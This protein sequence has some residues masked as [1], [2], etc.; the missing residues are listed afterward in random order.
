MQTVKQGCLDH[1][2]VVAE[3]HLA[4]L[5]KEFVEDRH[6]KGPHRDSATC[7]W[8]GRGRRG[9]CGPSGMVKHSR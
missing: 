1:V 8:C 6:E 5:V 4:H 7:P 3:C 9:C 2:L